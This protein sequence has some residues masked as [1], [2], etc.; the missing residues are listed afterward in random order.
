MKRRAA[1]LFC[2]FVFILSVK[3][4][5]TEEIRLQDYEEKA[6]SELYSGI[7]LLRDKKYK[8]AVGQL[9]KVIEVY[10]KS[11]VLAQAWYYLAKS[12]EERREYLLAID[13]YEKTVELMPQSLSASLELLNLCAK[14]DD[15]AKMNKV[16]EQVAQLYVPIDSRVPERLRELKLYTPARRCYQK[17]IEKGRYFGLP[18][19]DV[20]WAFPLFGT[21][22][23]IKPLVAD[24]NGDGEAEIVASSEEI[25]C[26]RGKDG[27][28]LWQFVP[29][30]I[31]WC[32][33]VLADLDGDSQLDI[34]ATS[35]D[36]VWALRGY[37][38]KLLWKIGDKTDDSDRVTGLVVGNFDGDSTP[39]IVT[40]TY[41]GTYCLS[42][43]DGRVIWKLVG[44]HLSLWTTF[45]DDVNKDGIEDL[46]H[47]HYKYIYVYNG[48]DGSKI[49][50]SLELPGEI[51]SHPETMVFYDIDKDNVKE[52]V[53]SAGKGMVWAI[54]LDGK[55][56][57]Q[58]R[59]YF[60]E[61]D[62]SWS[63]DEVLVVNLD[64]DPQEEIIV[65]SPADEGSTY[66]L[67]G[68]SGAVERVMPEWFTRA[69]LFD[70]NRDGTREVFG[71]LKSN[72]WR[73]AALSLN[74]IED[75][76][77]Y[78]PYTLKSSPIIADINN[79]GRM[80]IVGESGLFLCAFQMKAE[81]AKKRRVE[82]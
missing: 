44:T 72:N 25:F 19:G 26:L 81:K 66:I 41:K 76:A 30:G 80:E 54:N 75:A 45:V 13:A 68:K 53:V 48:K 23:K 59:A 21:E 52:L 34:V 33:P 29:E 17:L 18:S 49:I 51:L 46:V 78:F 24:L 43:K 37:D 70:Y 28:I 69:T 57:W 55:Q 4:I 3:G 60:K 10:P 39:D 63:I 31:I 67:D 8:E 71:S 62:S 74:A 36:M 27:T 65:S 77:W 7:R 58:T 12:Y 38:G 79:D 1:F 40:N 32:S 5:H 50:D 64:N 82:E 11:D 22:R 15:R 42:G 61:K 35:G 73:L 56:L 6:Q 20:I 16:A 2:I 9:K 14:V 47:V